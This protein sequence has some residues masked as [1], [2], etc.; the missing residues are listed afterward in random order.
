MFVR[1]RQE[2][3]SLVTLVL[4]TMELLLQCVFILLPGVADGSAFTSDYSPQVTIVICIYA[5]M[6]KEVFA[7]CSL[8][9]YT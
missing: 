8:R 6:D 7:T 9:L 4:Q 2:N 3:R 5:S 1:K